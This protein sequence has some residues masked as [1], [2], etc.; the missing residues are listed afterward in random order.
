MTPDDYDDLS[1]LPVEPYD[2]GSQQDAPPPER[3]AT[4]YQPEEDEPSESALYRGTGSDP[5]FGYLIALAL[6]F[7]LLPLLPNNADFR[8]TLAWGVLALFGV[9]SWLFGTTTRIERETIDNLAWGGVFGLII[10]APMLLIGGSTLTATIHLIFQTGIGAE[11]RSLPSGA[12]LAYLV[13]VMPLA[14]TLFFRGFMQQS[15]PMLLVGMLSSV[16]SLILFVPMLRV[17]EY[18]LIGII[19]SIVLVMINL[20][21]AYVRE[22]NGLAAA[23]VCQI[24][25]SFV[26]M[27][28]PYLM[29]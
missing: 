23:W 16:W 6:S 11:V 8:L 19:I 28:L 17:G 5:T 15:R 1:S 20:V 24:V 4:D 22:R 18:P 2:Y 21:Y 14:E 3:Y 13:F 12:V 25:I 10:A 7:G 9:L 26:L 29:P 27:F